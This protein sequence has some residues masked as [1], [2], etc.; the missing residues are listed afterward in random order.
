MTVQKQIKKKQ[1]KTT[2]TTTP[3]T[4]NMQVKHGGHSSDFSCRILFVMF[5]LGDQQPKTIYGL[6]GRKSEQEEE[7]L[8]LGSEACGR[9]LGVTQKTLGHPDPSC[10][11]MDAAVDC[12]SDRT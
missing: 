8:T 6:L 12:E 3:T 2:K 4:K 11:Q 7:P 5:C 10:R 9:R 1:K